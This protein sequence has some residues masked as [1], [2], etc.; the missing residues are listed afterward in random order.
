MFYG[1]SACAWIVWLSNKLQVLLRFGVRN[2]SGERNANVSRVASVRKA[3][4][5]GT[6]SSDE[7][8]AEMGKP[9]ARLDP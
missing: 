9:S 5:I 6:G 1:A 3:V 4:T 7:V 2:F 8:L